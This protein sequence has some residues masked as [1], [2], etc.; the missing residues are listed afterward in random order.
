MKQDELAGVLTPGGRGAVATVSVVGN[1]LHGLDEF[2]T[3][4]NGRSVADQP[5]NR[6]VF[7]QWG[8][9]HAED[10]VICRTSKDRVEI[11]CHGGDAA[12]QRILDDLRSL[13]V[14]ILTPT[15]LLEHTQSSFEAEWSS[16]VSQATTQKT[17]RILLQQRTTF[18]QAIQS[19]HDQFSS[20]AHEAAKRSLEELAGWS[21]F[22]RHLTQPWDVVLCGR[23]NVGK[24]SLIN[25][26]LGFQRAIVFD[27]PGTTRDIVRGETAIDG[28]PIRLA[29]TAGIRETT[30]SLESE[31]IERAR[32]LLA[33]ADLLLIVCDTSEPP[34]A[35]SQRLLNDFPNAIPVA[36][37]SDLPSRWPEDHMATMHRVSSE[38]REGLPELVHE[39][40]RRL[41]PKPP[42]CRQTVPFSSRQCDAIQLA[43]EA[44][45][46]VAMKILSDLIADSESQKLS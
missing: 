23:P 25:T 40:S 1:R 16:A 21:E 44:T 14:E 42:A 19:I 41:I 39:I 11:S 38:T 30:E 3:A 6:I 35:D 45:T 31:G 24:S 43:I 29:D 17:L 26:L 2:F 7:G 10:V 36:N 32:R 13:A 34:D 27:Q 12:T 15:D 8:R 4:V 20:G 5:V 18:P 33:D 46:E 9:E 22:G 28:W 37:K